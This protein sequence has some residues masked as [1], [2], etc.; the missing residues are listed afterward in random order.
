ML[1]FIVLI[2]GLMIINILL[3]KNLSLQNI[4]ELLIGEISESQKKEFHKRQVD[5][6]SEK[7]VLAYDTTSVSSTSK[8]IKAVKYRRNKDIENLSQINI[9]TIVGEF[10]RLPVYYRLLPGNISDVSTIKKLIYDI[11]F[12][13]IP[14]VKF[15]LDRVF[16]SSN[17]INLMYNHGYEFIISSRRNIAIFKDFLIDAQ[18]T[19]INNEQNFNYYDS[20]FDVY[21]KEYKIKWDYLENNEFNQIIKKEKR[22]LSVFIY[23]NEERGNQEKR[24]FYASINETKDLLINNKPLNNKQS[25]L[26]KKYFI[27][28]K[29]NDGSSASVEVDLTALAKKSKDYGFFI[30]LSNYN[31][32]SHEILSIYRKKDIIETCFDNLVDRL[33]FKH[34]EVLSDNAIDNKIFIMF[35]KSIYISYIDKVMK[36]NNL[37]KKFSMEQILDNL[38]T[39]KIYYSDDNKPIF[40]KITEQQRNLYKMFDVEPPV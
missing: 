34:T 6:R 29:N 9:A 27:I 19:F 14:N 39:I 36:Y 10:T 38:D 8:M 12:L 28:K 24:D 17:N 13:N 32:S 18:E 25:S 33:K 31:L 22:D 16:Y 4:S 15:V 23:Y 20:I 3:K 40:S 30:L 35:I 37:Y 11:E 21:S 7:E 5:R 2:D 1:H 26:S